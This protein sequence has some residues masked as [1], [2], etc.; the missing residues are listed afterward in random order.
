DENKEDLDESPDIDSTEQPETGKDEETNNEED[1]PPIASGEEPATTDTPAEEPPVEELPT[2]EPE[3]PAPAN[4]KD[5]FLV[6]IKVPAGWFNL[7]EKSV[8]VK[9]TPKS[10]A[11]WSKVL[12]R[13]DDGEWTEIKERFLL[14]DGY[15]FIDLT[16]TANGTM[17]IRVMN[18]AGDYF[19][20][21]K[22]I[23]IFD[24]R[25]PEVTA[26][27]KNT[28]LHVVAVDDLSEVAGIQVNGLLFTTLEDGVLDV[29]MEEPLNAY[30][31]LAV[32]A[33]DYAGNF[34]DPVTLDNPYYSEP[35]PTPA[36]TKK[37]T[38]TK[39]PTATPKPTSTPKATRK[40][41]GNSPTAKAT[42]SPSPTMTPAA[43]ET[44]QT[45]TQQPIIIVLTPLPTAEP[46]PSPTPEIQYVPLGPG[47]PFTQN[48]NMVTRDVLY[49][50]ST[51]KQFI[52][53]QSRAGQTYYMV[54]DYDKPIDEANEIYETYFLNLVDDRDL[55]SVLTDEE[56]VPTPTPQIIY[57]TP[58]PTQVPPPT[59]APV[60]TP[61]QENRKM[62]FT[63]MLLLLILIAL[64][65][66]GLVTWFITL[67]NKK[68]A[69][70]IPEFEEDEEIEDSEEDTD[71]DE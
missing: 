21:S 59:S 3:Q 8:R 9:I 2:E 20:M 67:Q 16:V 6:E 23:R 57:V 24:H 27:I 12:Y 39:Q 65:A 37:P 53:V 46:A 1:T 60:E 47:Q 19:D 63:T 40:P 5:L 33:Y 29:R 68:Q 56:I 31:Q 14:Q 62:D 55:M 13:Q 45:A 64:V 26:G 22:E 15:Y 66:G 36:P 70:R 10:E 43:A 61:V 42:A 51:N 35:T 28:M 48:G 34:S 32:R 4:L 52:S 11:L 25:A 49:S 69:P 18:E 58:E 38:L 50:A 71:S 41:S 7:P 44:V 17:N 30:R 54:I